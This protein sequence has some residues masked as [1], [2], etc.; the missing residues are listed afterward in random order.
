MRFT[1]MMIAAGL[2][3]ACSQQAAENQPAANAPAQAPPAANAAARAPEAN[4]ALPDERTPLA[5]PDGPI[6]PKSAEAAGQVVQ[7]YGALIEQ[8]RWTEAHALW[9]DPA[10]ARAFDRNWR[11]Y[12][13]VHLEIGNPGDMEGAAGSSYVTIPVIFYGDLNNGQ[14]SRLEAEIVLRRA[15]DVPGSTAAQRRWRIAR[16]DAAR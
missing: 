2:L 5:E 8:K 16:I 7:S 10:A 1:G 9:S 11:D 14:P 13:D 4:A 15:N 6:D 3:A 12:S